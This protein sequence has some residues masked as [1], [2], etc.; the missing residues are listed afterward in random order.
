MIKICD[1]VQA[2]QGKLICAYNNL[3]TLTIKDT[4]L[5]MFQMLLKCMSWQNIEEMTTALL[6]AK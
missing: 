2:M 6:T 4:E 3:R 5:A 1:A